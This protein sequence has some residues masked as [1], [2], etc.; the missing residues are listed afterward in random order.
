MG[1]VERRIFTGVLILLLAALGA[2]ALTRIFAGDQAPVYRV[3]IL[4]DGTEEDYWQNFRLGVEHAAQEHNVD[5]RQVTR[6]EGEDM[7]QAQAGTL[8]QELE[9]GADGVILVPINW[10]RLTQVLEEHSDSEA[11]VAVAGPGQESGQVGCCIWGD[12]LEMGGKLAGAVAEGGQR[13]C[14]VY[15]SRSAGETAGLYYQGLAEGLAERGISCR[16]VVFTGEEALQMPEN[17]GALAAV[18]PAV[19]E[20]LCRSVGA[21]G[22]IYG[23]G[24]SD[25]LLHCLEDGLVQALVV[26]CDYNAGYL[27]LLSLLGLIEGAV[28][29]DRVLESYVV[30][31]E[32]MFDDPMDQILFPIS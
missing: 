26:Q 7:G 23:I 24:A 15:L 31:A 5:V 3:S 6:Y 2:L 16:K 18:E 11:K 22:E 20:Q 4:L 25:R 21:G 8:G 12:P 32:N 27:S 19:T 30:T 14:T 10:G 29:E 17:G 1:K 9:N 28:Q 13:T